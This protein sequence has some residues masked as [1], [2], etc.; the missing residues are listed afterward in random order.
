MNLHNFERSFSST[1]LN[2]GR[3]Y[4]RDGRVQFL[5]KASGESQ[6]EWFA[7][8]EGR[9]DEYE[10]EIGLLANGHIAYHTCECPYDWGG[11][12]KHIAAV[13]FK[14]REE[15]GAMTKQRPSVPAPKPK[16]RSTEELVKAYVE[17]DETEQRLLKIAAVLMEPTSQTKLMELFNEAKFSNRS[18]NLYP[19]EIKP[20]LEKLVNE[21]FFTITYQQ[22]G[23]S[24][25]LADALCNAITTR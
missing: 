12:C 13:L 15:Q 8:V 23:C 11:P 19:A 6:E 21:G 1:I 5:E 18:K 25:E 10:V 4:F 2:R 14:I 16:T 7:L 24:I 9:G 22:Y 20:A 17:L 3:A